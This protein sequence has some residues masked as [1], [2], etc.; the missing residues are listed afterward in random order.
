MMKHTDIDKLRAARDVLER[1]GFTTEHLEGQIA[2][3][4]QTNE[5]ECTQPVDPALHLLCCL[6]GLGVALHDCRP[7]VPN[8]EDADMELLRE[9]AFDVLLARNAVLETVAEKNP[10]VWNA[11]AQATNPDPEAGPATDP[12]AEAERVHEKRCAYARREQG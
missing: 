9:A 1:H 6:D 7:R 11:I 5:D 8:V 12:D 3:A 2:A 4:V 10:T